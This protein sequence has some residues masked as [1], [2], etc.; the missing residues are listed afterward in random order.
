MIGMASERETSLRPV[1]DDLQRIFGTRLQAIVAYGWHRHG[2]ATSLALVDSLTLD[3]LDACAARVPQ[4]T[5]AGAATPLLLT[6]LEFARSLDAFPIE[7]GEIIAQHT[8]VFGRDPFEGLSIRPDDLRRACEVQAKSH[9]LHL[10]ENYLEAARSPHE[11]ADLVSESAPGFV[12]L[13]RLVA[14]LNDVP[15]DSPPSL[16]RFAAAALRLDGHLVDDLR[17]LADGET[18]SSIDAARLFP[19]YLRNL[20]RLVEYVDRWRPA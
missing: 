8:L 19:D 14:R 12:G 3:D 10:R 13:L 1:S 11:I 4:W 7:Y 9:L 2:P 16:G 15:L 6:S 18:P 17:E 20:E 5:R